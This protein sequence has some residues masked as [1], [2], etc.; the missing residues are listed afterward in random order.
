[1]EFAPVDFN[2][3]TET[4]INSKYEFHKLFQKFCIGLIIGLMKDLVG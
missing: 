3:A 4:V 1:M 2:S